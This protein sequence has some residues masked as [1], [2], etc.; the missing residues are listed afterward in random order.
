MVSDPPA[1]TADEGGLSFAL[2]GSPSSDLQNGEFER[3]KRGSDPTSGAPTTSAPPVT[4]TTTPPPSTTT[5][6]P[7]S[8]T[9][10]TPPPADPPPPDPEPAQPGGSHRDQVTALVNR[11]RQERGCGP[12]Q[13]D[14]RLAAAAQGHAEDMSNRDY[15]S[16][17][18]PEG[19][20]FDQRIRNAGHPS[21]GAENI[22]YGAR[23]AEQ[24][25]EM[26]MESDGHRRNILNCDLSTIGVGLDTD[27]W[28]WVQNFGW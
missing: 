6:P 27:G 2:P 15:F 24:V 7:P 20:T 13:V 18:T 9:S 1:S 5:T 4:S 8:T 22:A 14:S 11:E 28:Y 17:T 19:V 21:P 26:W 10:E 16:H 25:M 3:G 12:V 23:S